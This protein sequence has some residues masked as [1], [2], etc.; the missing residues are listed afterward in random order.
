MGVLNC[1]IGF[2]LC[3]AFFLPPAPASI[4]TRHSSAEQFPRMAHP[5]WVAE[6]CRLWSE[7]K[8]IIPRS[9]VCVRANPDK[10]V[11]VES[12]DVRTDAWSHAEWTEPFVD[13]EGD[14]KPS[15][16]YFS[17]LFLDILPQFCNLV[18]MYLDCAIDFE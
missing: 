12:G 6:K 3:P 10:P 1:A 16:W 17:V 11:D 15:P 8:N 18:L 5:D 14:K 9:Y 2:L 4:T 13:I 7:V